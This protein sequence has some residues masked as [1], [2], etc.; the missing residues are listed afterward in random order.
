[1][2]SVPRAALRLPM[3][4]IIGW[5]LCSVG[6]AR[7][8]PQ[9]YDVVPDNRVDEQLFLLRELE[10]LHTGLPADF[11]DRDRLA[12]DLLGTR[13]ALDRLAAYA[14]AKQMNKRLIAM[15]DDTLK[16]VDQ[17]SGLLI[18]LGALDQNYSRRLAQLS[19]DQ[20]IDGWSKGL[21]T[22]SA[23]AFVG[24]EPTTASVVLGTLIIKQ[25]F[26]AYQQ[27]QHLTDEQSL[28]AQRRVQ[29]FL[30]DRSRLLGRIEVQAGVLAEQ[31]GWAPP[32]VGFDHSLASAQPVIGASRSGNLQ[33]LREALR[34]GCA[35][36]GL[37]G[38]QGPGNPLF[39]RPASPFLSA[40]DMIVTV[41][42]RQE[43]NS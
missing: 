10:V 8:K 23:L 31:Y 17:Y 16:L 42:P 25:S 30:V 43:V 34:D 35:R 13:H 6:C 28:A 39:G 38:N 15:Y 2:R 9:A 19:V 41:L 22:G 29:Q 3:V 21:E 7:G 26:E 18:D 27:R 20:S 24:A 40:L 32:E 14:R 4:T 37:L 1:M 12:E 11:D 5:L 33:S 36:G